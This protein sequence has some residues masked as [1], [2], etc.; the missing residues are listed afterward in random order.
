[1]CRTFLWTRPMRLRRL[2]R[3]PLQRRAPTCREL[4]VATGTWPTYDLGNPLGKFGL[5]LACEQKPCLAFGY[6]GALSG[7]CHTTYE[8]FQ[9]LFWCVKCV[10]FAQCCSSR[11]MCFSCHTLSSQKA[12][13]T[14]WQVVKEV[15][16]K[17]TVMAKSS[18]VCAVVYSFIALI[19][20]CDLNSRTDIPLI[21]AYLHQWTV[22]APGHGAY[23][24][25][26]GPCG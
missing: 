3:R 23:W 4:H 12:C 21:D 26:C 17:Y 18:K 6:E 15:D 19:T 25:A 11:S 16:A 22:L 24:R 5:C 10:N 7:P 14:A 1:M 20:Q 2:S 8:F 13:C 9:I